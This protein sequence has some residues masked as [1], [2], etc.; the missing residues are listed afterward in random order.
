MDIGRAIKHLRPSAHWA[1]SGETYEG[2]DW[3]DEGE[4]PTESECQLAWE[5]IKHDIMLEPIREQRS[6]TL[7]MCDWTQLPDAPVD[8]EA[9]ATYRQ[10]LRDLP[11]SITNPMESFDWPTPPE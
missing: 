8:A 6:R 9:W 10:E 2:L 11:E 7:F 5:E 1:L 4:P 3:R